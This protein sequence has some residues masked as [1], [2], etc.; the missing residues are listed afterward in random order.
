MLHQ[1]KRE[2]I[3]QIIGDLDKMHK[4]GQRKKI[5]GKYYTAML[6]KSRKSEAQ[7]EARMMR[8]AGAN[9]RIIKEGNEYYLYVK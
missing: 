9:V 2:I 3:Y 7:A 5:A 4:L 6:H 8:K 1:R